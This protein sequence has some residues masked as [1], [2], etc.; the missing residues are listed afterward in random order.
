MTVYHDPDPLLD[1]PVKVAV[2]VISTELL[3][4]GIWAKVRC[5]GASEESIKGKTQ[6]FF[7]QKS[8]RVHICYRSQ[9]S[10]VSI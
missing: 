10:Q 3:D 5:L 6:K 2:L 7:R 8:A 9:A 1:P 4:E